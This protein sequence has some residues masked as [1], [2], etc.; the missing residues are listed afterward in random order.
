[1]MSRLLTAAGILVLVAVP[2]VAQ[3]PAK[4]LV[5][6]QTAPL[7]KILSD[8]RAAA[9]I[10]GGPELAKEFDNNLKEVLGEKGFSGIDLTRRIVAY[11]DLADEA[12][13]SSGVVVIPITSEDE[14]KAL[15]GRLG[16]YENKG[17]L[18]PVD[19]QPGLYAVDTDKAEADYPVRLRFHDRAAYLGF[20]V[21]DPA[22]AVK[23]LLPA[24]GLIRPTDNSFFAYEFHLAQYKGNGKTQL[25][26]QLATAAEQLDQAPLP[27]GAKKA[28]EEI[29]ALVKRSSTSVLDDGDVAA[30]RFKFDAET[31]MAAIETALIPKPGTPLAADLAAR[32]PTTNKFAGLVGQDTTVGFVTRLPLFTTELRTAAV[33][34]IDEGVGMVSGDVPEDFQPLADEAKAGLLRTVKTGQFD[35]AAALSGPNEDDQFGVAVAIAF[36]DTT[37]IEKQ[38]RDL[39]DKYK[40]D[41]PALNFIKL[42][43][44]QVNGVNIHEAPLGAFV[45]EPAQAI[46][47]KGSSAYF[48]FGPKGIYV[49]FGPNALDAIKAAIALK[50]AQADVVDIVVNPARLKT[51]VSIADP[52]TAKEMAEMLGGPDELLSAFDMSVEGGKELRV[53]FGM[54]LKLIPRGVAT[55]A[56]TEQAFPPDAPVEKR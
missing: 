1:M 40:A 50:P 17:K 47:G 20:N 46:F 6:A 54:N 14:F 22:M 12:E 19:G 15:I 2:A 42:D 27:P 41:Q 38:L 29:L 30:Y 23:T 10:L 4:P 49:T 43:A 18:T 32:V 3:V 34:G 31:G 55:G 25:A 5:T 45:P 28:G 11:G 35:I 8:V 56:E 51:L 9:R 7:G 26:K 16:P 53:K 48:A 33:A 37:K 39:F 24:A 13:K 36:E 52:D 21:P 44:A